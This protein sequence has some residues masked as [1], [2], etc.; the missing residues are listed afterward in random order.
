MNNHPDMK[1]RSWTAPQTI[2]LPDFLTEAQ[3]NRAQQCKS[4]KEV[5]EKVI[6]PAI[7]EI[8]RRLGQQNDPMYLAHMV[9]YVF[10]QAGIWR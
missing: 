1:R 5:K 9:E 8:D 3:L 2:T 7:E 10:R 6:Q 4:A